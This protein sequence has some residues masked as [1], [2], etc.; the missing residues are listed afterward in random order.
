MIQAP[1]GYRWATVSG[2]SRRHMVKPGKEGEA[3]CGVAILVESKDALAPESA[4]G[5]RKCRKVLR[6]NEG[7]DSGIAGHP[8]ADSIAAQ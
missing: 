8:R 5:C 7:I 6:A 2:W 4:V 1:K 3:L